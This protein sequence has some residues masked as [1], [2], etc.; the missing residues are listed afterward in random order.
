MS[1]AYK[2]FQTQNGKIIMTKM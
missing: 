2:I 1:K